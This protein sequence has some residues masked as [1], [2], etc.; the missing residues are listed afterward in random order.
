MRSSGCSPTIWTRPLIRRLPKRGFNNA[1]HTTRYIAVNL[2]S[3]NRFEDGANVDVEILRRAGL[4]NGP[5]KWITGKI[6]GQ[7][8]SCCRN[9]RREI[10]Q[11]GH[12][13]RA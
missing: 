6:C 2:D 4:A 13:P 11:S 1:R 10:D 3:L 7:F 9:I 12:M 5:V 8:L